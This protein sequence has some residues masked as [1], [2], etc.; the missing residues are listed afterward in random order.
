MKKNI[1]L[2]LS[3][4]AICAGCSDEYDG[5]FDLSSDERA[6]SKLN[7]YAT[8][9]QG[10]E[11]GWL[12]HYYP[13][14]EDMG[15]FSFV[16]KFS[17]DGK[18]TMN[19]SIRD[20]M[21]T[22][23][24]S[25]K[26]IDK[27]MMIFDTYCNFTKLADPEMG[28]G[29]ENELAFVRMSEDQDTIYMEERVKKD[30]IILVRATAE[31]WEGI[32]NYPAQAQILLRGNGTEVPFFYNLHVEGWD[33]PVMMSYYDNRQ[34]VNL[35]YKEGNE[36]KHM[37]MGVN[38]TADG[39]EFHTPL[40]RNGISVCSF[41]YDAVTNEHTIVDAGVKGKFAHESTGATDI[42]GIAQYYFG[43]GHFGEYATYVS[44]KAV[45]VF[46]SMNPEGTLQGM[47]YD[48]FSDSFASL[49][50]EFTNGNIRFNNPKYVVIGENSV[51]M[52]ADE[53]YTSWNFSD[54]E[55]NAMME[56]ETGQQLRAT[57]LAPEGWTIVPCYMANQYN[58]YF[59]FI[60]N[61]DPEIYFAFGDMF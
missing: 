35:F 3:L 30:P 49:S 53:G 28:M 27:P 33:S 37:I 25:L 6:N 2:L 42:D 46:A 57:M 43:P 11:Y 23:L 41:R 24:Y 22:S 39:F 8:V 18:V 56:S 34:I 52:T 55:I 50:V 36:N 54:E 9:L 59:Y 21:Q 60:S 32:K 10:S 1:F 61:V 47:S 15:G 31:V 29:G 4:L 38:F 13:H 40:T 20:E 14:P 12:T 45:R 26:M 5:V 58:R 48:P 17:K 16:M 51:K 7:E 19:W 44:P